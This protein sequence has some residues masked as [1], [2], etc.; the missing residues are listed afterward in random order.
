VSSLK[1]VEQWE[2]AGPVAA[3]APA[4]GI[5]TAHSGSLPLLSWAIAASTLHRL[6]RGEGALLAINLS[7]I[8][9]Q[10]A[11]LSWS[12]A[13][14]L[15]SV[16]VIGLMYAFNDF[17]DAPTDSNNPKKD[18]ALISTYLDHRGMCAAAIFTLKL[19]TLLFA[20]A[21]LGA[22]VTATAAGVMLVNVVYSTAFKGIPV[23]DVIGCG[24]WGLLYAAIVGAPPSLLI[25]VGLMTAVCH[26]YQTLDDRAADAANGINTTA[27][28]S[29]VLSRNVLIAL[30]ILLF[31]ALRA[32][33]GVWAFTSFTPLLLFF[34]TQRAQ[35]GWLLTKV[36][37]GVTWLCILE[38]ARA[39]V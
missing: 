4:V 19:V 22:W 33:L 30:S 1:A 35:T 38:A 5:G 16:A 6:R 27:V 13:Q 24:L 21:T 18:Q 11:S 32:P 3:T 26:L 2:Y 8:L 39:S 15:V 23:V 20:F 12:L 29:A 37:F 34:V 17:Y 36:Y 9:Q 14:A 25:V 31:A 28:R 7:L 10:G